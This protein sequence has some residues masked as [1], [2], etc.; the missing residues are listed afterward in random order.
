MTGRELILWILVNHLEDEPVFKDGSMPG[1]KTV[2]QYAAA[3]GVGSAT[4]RAWVKMGSTPHIKIGDAIYIPD[5]I[6]MER[7]LEQ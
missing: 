7:D 4:V 2:D 5:A 3:H 1:F 6:I